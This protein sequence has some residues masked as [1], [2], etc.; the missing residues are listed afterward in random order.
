MTSGLVHPLCVAL[1]W[2]APPVMAQDAV[3]DQPLSVIDWL[4]N[5]PAT[6]PAAL[7][8]EEPDVAK[9]GSVSVVTVAPLGTDVARIIG[10][11]P[12]EVTGLPRTLWAGGNAASLARQIRTMPKPHLPAAQ[13]LFYT[14]L[15]AESHAPDGAGDDF[16]QA[17]VD[18]LMRMGALEPA[19]EMLEQTGPATNARIMQR[20]L[21]ATLLNDTEARACAA[22]ADAPHLAPGYASRVFCAARSGDW[23]TADLLLGTARAL[24]VIPSHEIAALERFLDPDLFEDAASLARLPAP[25]ALMFRVYEALGQPISTKTWPRVYA[26]ADLR[27]V[28]GWKAQIEA[29][30][31]LAA[32]GALS[33]NR[34]LGIY[35]AR[36]PAASGG[37][38]DRVS[39]VQR[40]ETALRS[41]S[42]D[43]VAKT[44]PIAWTRMKSAGLAVP[45]STLF[46]P[47]V[48]QF[49][50]PEPAR[51]LAYRMILLSPDYEKATPP[52]P[53]QAFL[54]DLAKGAPGPGATDAE[55][56]VAEAFRPDTGNA[57]AG[58]PS[59]PL[60]QVLLQG[61]SDLQA[62]TG[63]DLTKFT[64]ALSVLRALG[65]EDTARRAALQ[66]LILD[67][68]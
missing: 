40:F 24:D 18:A 2:V 57:A 7:V 58:A 63:G 50:L 27:D 32:T 56:A 17:R 51:S 10:L 9:S 33:D 13:A 43:A 47:D 37:V 41:G 64:Q 5:Q 20:Y 21:T 28:A 8:P 48:T 4:D 1:F 34:L 42:T 59:E 16:Q 19:L 30:E 3:S 31:R 29:A 55:R 12:A 14:L 53:S 45:F 60:G 22:I 25:D 46:A 62:G 54:A 26:N 36:R 66:F 67:P 11:V 38:W 44:L 23:K 52:D 39:A 6:Q 49:D 68:A 65:L 15:L 35:S 61:L